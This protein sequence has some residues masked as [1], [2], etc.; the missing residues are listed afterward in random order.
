MQKIVYPIEYRVIQRNITPEKSYWHFLKG[1]VFYNPLNLPSE[2]DIEF[3]F[4]T[5]KR[6]LPLSYSESMEVSQGITW[7]TC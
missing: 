7:Q 1:R 4:G 2:G 5:T 6:K 3:M